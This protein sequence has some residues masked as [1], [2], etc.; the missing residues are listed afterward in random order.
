MLAFQVFSWAALMFIVPAVSLLRFVAMVIILKVVTDFAAVTATA[1]FYSL[2]PTKRARWVSK[3]RSPKWLSTARETR[4]RED[5][6]HCYQHRYSHVKKL[7]PKRI[8]SSP[9]AH[10]DV[11][12]ICEL[13]EQWRFVGS[14]A[15]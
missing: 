8:T 6:E 9:I 2:I 3:N 13:D 15:L 5:T 12:L 1:C 4:Y 7:A 10:A 14:K 11:V